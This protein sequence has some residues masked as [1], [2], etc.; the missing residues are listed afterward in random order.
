MGILEFTIA[1]FIFPAFKSPSAWDILIPFLGFHN[2]GALHEVSVQI[3][4]AYWTLSD[5]CTRGSLVYSHSRDSQKQRLHSRRWKQNAFV[6]FVCEILSLWD[7]SI[8]FLPAWQCWHKGMHQRCLTWVY[9]VAVSEES[10]LPFQLND[11]G[12]PFSMIRILQREWSIIYIRGSVTE[13]NGTLLKY[14]LWNHSMK[15]K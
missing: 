10:E 4:N 11:I 6:N 15:L 3:H 2:Q 5:F 14:D 8:W 9:Y 12:S 1:L 13:W 7:K